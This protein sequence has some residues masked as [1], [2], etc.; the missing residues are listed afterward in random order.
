M[1]FCG[2]PISLAGFTAALFT[3]MFS[4][5]LGFFAD[6]S[7]L[8]K[9]TAAGISAAVSENAYQISAAMMFVGLCM[10]IAARQTKANEKRQKGS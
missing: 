3:F 9:E 1:G 10:L 2:V 4:M 8:K 6:L 7:G 5:Q